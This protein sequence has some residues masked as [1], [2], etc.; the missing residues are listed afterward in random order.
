MY[1]KTLHPFER[2]HVQFLSGTKRRINV[3]DS[4]K[5]VEWGKLIALVDS[6]YLNCVLAKKTTETFIKTE[7]RNTADFKYYIISI[8]CFR[9]LNF[10]EL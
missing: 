3:S 7:R 4:I 9:K 10:E 8:N 6:F 1:A 2:N 5:M